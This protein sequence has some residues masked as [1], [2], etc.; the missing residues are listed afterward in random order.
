MSKSATPKW[1]LSPEWGVGIDKYN[2]ILYRK[3]PKRWDAV[4]FYPSPELLLKSLY[5][6]MLRTEPADSDLVRHVE[7]ISRRVEGWAARL[8]EQINTWQA[9]R[10]N[11]GPAA[12]VAV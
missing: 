5:R 11:S 12:R 10:G 2:W 3:N 9:V 8:F 4:G 6:K 7:A 1:I